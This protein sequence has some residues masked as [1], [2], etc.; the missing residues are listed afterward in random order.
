MFSSIARPSVGRSLL[1][2]VSRQQQTRGV[3]SVKKAL[4]KAG[5]TEEP[6]DIPALSKRMEAMSEKDSVMVF[7]SGTDL[8][9]PVLPENKAEV[10]AL[11]ASYKTSVKM[12]DGRERM[13]VIKQ[14]RARPNQNPLNP[15]KYWKISFDDDGAVGERWKN[16]LMNWNSTADTYGCDPPLFFKNAEDAVFF[17]EKRGWKYLVNEPVVRK[18]RSD[19]AQYQD[20]FLPQAV[21]GKVK[22]EGTQCDHWKRK[23]AGSSHYFRPLKFHGDGVVRQHG[24][25]MHQETD[26]HAES[27]PKIR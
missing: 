8:P 22:R 11:D 18:L 12:P 4:V 27:Y 10:A 17:A 6:E 26:P 25:N 13:V 15:E 21:A 19:D 14:L 7:D 23:A 5:E 3:V 9:A 24:P 20:N 1:T 16:T 2:R